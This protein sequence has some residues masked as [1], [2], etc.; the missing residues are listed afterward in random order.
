MWSLIITGL[1][2]LFTQWLTNE[3]KVV[4]AKHTRRV[5]EIEN[6]GT[7][8]VEAQKQMRHSW[9]D[10]YLILI[11][12]FLIWGYAIPSEG[13]TTRLNLVWHKMSTA[14]AEWW[15]CYFGMIVST[16]GLRWMVNSKMNRGKLNERT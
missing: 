15:W 10:E 3:Q 13:L 16:F 2:S 9:K 14:P 12:T 8:D 7:Y 11:H 1:T 4:D 6:E 5:K